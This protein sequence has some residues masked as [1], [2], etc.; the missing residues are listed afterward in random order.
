MLRYLQITRVTTLNQ[1]LCVKHIV[2]KCWGLNKDIFGYMETE[3]F[4]LTG[5]VQKHEW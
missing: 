3:N 5:N 2:S 4:F 1:K